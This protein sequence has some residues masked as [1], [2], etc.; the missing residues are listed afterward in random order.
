IRPISNTVEIFV[1]GLDAAS[2]SFLASNLGLNS[3]MGSRWAKAG[4]SLDSSFVSPSFFSSSLLLSSIWCMMFSLV[5][6]IWKRTAFHIMAPFGASLLNL[7]LSLAGFPS[8]GFPSEGI[9][10]ATTCP[11]A[12]SFFPSA[13]SGNLGSSCSTTMCFLR[14]D[15]PLSLDFNPFGFPRALN[16]TCAAWEGPL[17][18][19]PLLGVESAEASAGK[20]VAEPS[21]VEGMPGFGSWVLGT[22]K[23]PSNAFLAED[24][25]LVSKGVLGAAGFG[26][27]YE[28]VLGLG[29]LETVICGSDGAEGR[30]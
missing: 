28:G 14:R 16:R 21:C 10:S 17:S 27:S 23:T 29:E 3:R 7:S 18:S 5:E 13:P 26:A 6:N 1:R 24:L 2:L 11:T 22:P 30:V 9:A 8:E 15:H 12:S 20:P 4:I 19:F 25:A